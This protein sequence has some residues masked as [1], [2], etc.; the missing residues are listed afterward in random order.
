MSPEPTLPKAALESPLVSATLAFARTEHAG[1][2]RKGDGSPYIGH[3]IEV[4]SLLHE[5]GFRETVIAAALLHD[6]VEDCGVFVTDLEERFGEE[7]AA[8][9]ATLTADESIEGYAAG[10]DYHRAAVKWAGSPATAIYAA[11]KLANL[12][13][14]TSAYREQG[15]RLGERFNASLDVKLAHARRDVE[16]LETLRPP[17]PCLAELKSE[18]ER[19]VHLR[20]VNR[21]R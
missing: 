3:P 14:L 6:V 9:V 1:Q 20:Q 12:R 2:T 18:L 17:P 8:L 11:D 19:I 7:V 5:A 16:M 21:S 4:A 15:E 13:S 10:K